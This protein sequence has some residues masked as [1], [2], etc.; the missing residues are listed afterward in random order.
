MSGSLTAANSY[1]GVSPAFI[2]GIH[3]RPFGSFICR[4]CNKL[5][6]KPNKSGAVAGEIKCP[7]CGHINEV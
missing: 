7:R 4:E 5:L 1:T 2:E 6:A 3:V